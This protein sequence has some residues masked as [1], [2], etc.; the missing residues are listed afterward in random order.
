MLLLALYEFYNL[1]GSAQV[2]NFGAGY[3]EGASSFMVNPASA[4]LGSTGYSFAFSHLEW[5][6]GTRVESFSGVY[7]LDKGGFGILLQYF[8]SGDIPLTKELPG[9]EYDETDYGSFSFQQFRGGIGYSRAFQPGFLN[10]KVGGE[11]SF[12][13]AKVLD[14]S[15]MG[16]ALSLGAIIRRG[17]LKASLSIERLGAASSFGGNFYLLSPYLTLSGVYSVGLFSGSSLEGRAGVSAGFSTD[18]YDP[19]YSFKGTVSLF[20]IWKDV[21]SLSI[22]YS[23]FLLSGGLTS[24]FKAGLGL[25]VGRYSL[26]YEMLPSSV[27]GYV[28]HLLTVQIDF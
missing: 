7:S 28:F 25:M 6:L 4:Y 16:G 21:I 20:Y 26:A 2:D 27:A 1:P 14:Y 9:G 22:G 13:L 24:G 12:L 5:F 3:V 11:A 23:Q 8:S 17:A 19:L 10:L 15:S 18:F